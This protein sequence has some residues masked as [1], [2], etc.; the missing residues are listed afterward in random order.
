MIF[1]IF[2]VL[3]SL[4]SPAISNATIFFD[5]DWENASAPF[6]GCAQD[7][8]DGGNGWAPCGRGALEV[9]PSGTDGVTAKSGSYMLRGTF[10][11]VEGSANQPGN[12]NSFPNTNHLFG[13]FLYTKSP[14]F[15][16]GSNN[17]TKIFLINGTAYP[18]LAIELTGGPGYIMYKFYLSSTYDDGTLFPG[19]AVLLDCNVS[20]ATAPNWDEIQ[21]EAKIN[22]PGAANGYIRMWVNGH[23]CINYQNHQIVGPTT[24]STAGFNTPGY[25]LTPSNQMW[26]AP[27]I[28]VQSGLG[29]MYMDRVAF[30]DQCI[31]SVI[32]GSL[33]CSGSP[34]PAPTPTKPAAPKNLRVQ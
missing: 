17:F 12:L 24:K 14:N 26:N 16:V 5:T 2:L 3:L 28:F 18:E 32:D 11:D 4:G 25:Q 13:R 9:V 15:Q 10:T 29:Q 6:A 31:P 27:E 1:K 30:G 22:D 19:D 20:S 21:F 7:G 23:Q 34:S 8:W 33:P